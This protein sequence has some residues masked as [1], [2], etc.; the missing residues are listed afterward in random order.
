MNVLDDGDETALC[1][2]CR[3]GNVPVVQKLIE[4]GAQINGNDYLHIST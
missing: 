4:Q 3:K 2:A 1:R